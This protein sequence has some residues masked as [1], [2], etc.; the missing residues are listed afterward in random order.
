MKKRVV[1]VLLAVSVVSGMSVGTTV[2]AAEQKTAEAADT[3]LPYQPKEG[4]FKYQRVAFEIESM[5]QTLDIVVSA[6]EEETEFNLQMF[7]FGGDA[8]I[9]V[10]VDGDKYT[11][12]NDGGFFQNEGPMVVKQALE[13]G[14]WIEIGAEET[15][16]A[17][18]GDTEDS[19]EE[20]VDFGVE[21]EFEPNKAYDKY[22]VLAYTIEA[23]D[24]DLVVTISA[25][26]DDSE[27]E[28]LCNFYGDDQ[29]A[30]A[31][32]DGKEFKVTEDKTGFMAGDAP[33]ILEKA[34]ENDK[35]A[36]IGAEDEKEEETDDKAAGDDK[37]AEAAD[38]ELPYP[39]KEGFF[40]YQRID[41]EI[42]S[43]GQTLDIVV[44]ANEEETEFNL[45]MFFFGGDADVNVSVD[46]DKYTVTNDG[47][48]FQNEGPMVVQKALEEGNWTEIK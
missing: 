37:T 42:E 12:T 41:F 14:E 39:P 38:T 15:I 13:Q 6:N 44:S 33:A 46:G 25:K 4:F 30:V 34:L 10:S 3:E 9:D 35:W 16:A 29:K 2:S 5:G 22:T 31:T 32:Y 36:K 24:T 11:V 45:Q 21:P 23:I 47:G 28:I 20:K 43:M 8:D 7:F 1:A 17:E 40:K 18:T 26:E 27:F 19:K 48:F